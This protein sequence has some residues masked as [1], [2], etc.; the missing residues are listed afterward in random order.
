M[1][2]LYYL[3]LLFFL[4]AAGCSS[5]DTQVLPA[6][7][8]NL[9]GQ[10]Q[11]KWNMTAFNFY[12]DASGELLHELTKN[13][14]C[15]Y[16]GYIELMAGGHEIVGYYIAQDNCFEQQHPGTWTLDEDNREI[17]LTINQTGME[18]AYKVVHIDQHS[19]ELQVI[20]EGG[21]SPAED[22]I[23]MRVLLEK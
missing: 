20:H 18:A 12:D 7:E 16:F 23:D 17:T 8:Q 19:L 2:Q 11:A 6:A 13:G 3:P 4:F 14:D 22:G 21:S 9:E 15:T 10:L 5:D 1:K